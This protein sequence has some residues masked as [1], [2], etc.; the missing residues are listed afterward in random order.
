[1]SMAH[2]RSWGGAI[3]S[4]KLGVMWHANPHWFKF[5]AVAYSREKSSELDM[6]RKSIEE[7]DK[8]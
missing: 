1:M 4:S 6:K 7:N 5:G 8:K 2:G 3:G